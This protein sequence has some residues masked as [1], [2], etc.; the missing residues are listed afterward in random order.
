MAKDYTEIQ[1]LAVAE[2][3]SLARETRESIR[4]SRFDRS[5][6]EVKNTRQTRA[7]RKKLARIETAIQQKRHV[8]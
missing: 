5:T 4:Q 6:K 1:S 2:L 8:A 7:L 3:E